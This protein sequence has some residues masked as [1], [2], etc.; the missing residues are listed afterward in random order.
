MPDRCDIHVDLPERGPVLA[1]TLYAHRRQGRES[2]SF[3][4][5]A[6]W[7]ADPDAYP[8]DPALPLVEGSFHTAEGRSMFGAF[9]DAAPDR[10]GRRLIQRGERERARVEDVAERS[11][12]EFEFLLGVRDDL[13]QGSIRCM[14][15]GDFVASSDHGVPH[16]V[17]L[18]AL[19]DATGRI[20][21]DAAD[22]DDLRA[23]L[24]AGSSLGGARPKSHVLDVDGRLS[25]AKFPSSIAD[26]W[27]VI[28]W[29]YVTLELARRAGIDVPA[30]SLIKVDD[31]DVLVVHRFDRVGAERIG[32]ASAMTLLEAADG[33]A[34]SYLEIA[35][36][37]SQES[38]RAG[39]DLVEL[40]RRMAFSILVSNSDDHLRNHGFL[41]STGGWYLSPAFDINPNPE[42]EGAFLSTSIEFGDRRADIDLLMGVAN[43][44]RLSGDSARS[45]LRTVIGAVDQWRDV[46]RRTGLTS[47]E[48]ERMAPAFERDQAIVAR[49]LV[50]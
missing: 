6:S 35:D 3:S 17:D 13:R 43:Y 46:A 10:W 26:E 24:R 40:W 31:R 1:G 48:V 32:Y 44:F 39:V 7:V 33:D 21:R 18:G 47:S 38:P 29:E 30:A 27:N 34:G 45:E 9:T 19:L 49:R 4:Y 25:I 15:G 14:S 28:A 41:R 20:E 2:A 50:G 11:H 23:L 16:L 37:I 8:L 42:P 36:V 5:A 12:G 22:A